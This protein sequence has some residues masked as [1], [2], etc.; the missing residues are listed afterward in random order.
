MGGASPPFAFPL[1][2]FY[3]ELTLELEQRKQVK[4]GA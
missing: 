3:K 4:I 1:Y 2:E